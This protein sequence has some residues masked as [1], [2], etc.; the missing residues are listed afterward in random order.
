MNMTGMGIGMWIFWVVVFIAVVLLIKILISSNNKQISSSSQSP[1]E[2]LK[3][4]YANGDID[5]EEYE[6]RKKELEV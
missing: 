2:T 3:K 5:D 6:R 1:I 4:R